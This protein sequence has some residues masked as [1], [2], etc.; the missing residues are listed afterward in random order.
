MKSSDR[1]EFSSR[2]VLVTGATSGIGLAC[3]ELL[4]AQGAT[5]L[6]VGRDGEQLQRLLTSHGERFVPLQCDL[7]ARPPREL[8]ERVVEA[9]GAQRA[10]YGIVHSA[11]IIASGSLAQTDDELLERMM[12]LNLMVPFALTRELLGALRRAKN[13]A[14]SVVNV[15][16]VAGLRPYANLSAYCISKAALDQMTRCLAIELASEKIRVNAV[17]P[18]VVV[19]ALHRRGGMSEQEYEAFLERGATTHPL[20]RVGQADEIAEAVVYLLGERSGWITGET[21]SIDGGR[22]LTSAR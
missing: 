17:N 11:G 19:S 18:G 2:R 9:L 15:S 21:L 22:H 16:S 4:I 20:G 13:P 7:L 6:G 12:R 14:A 8:A 5:V 3:V 10:L 1:S